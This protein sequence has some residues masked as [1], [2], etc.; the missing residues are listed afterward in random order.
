MSASQSTDLKLAEA[1]AECERLREENRRLREGMWIPEK[2]TSSLLAGVPHSPAAVTG[3]STPGE[4]VKLFRSL[5]RGR[6]DVYALRWEGRNGQAG[7]SPAYRKVWSNPLSKHPDEPKEYFP[8]TDQVIHDHLKGI[9][10]AG[11]YPLLSDETCWFLAADFDKATWQEDV[12]A[13]LRTCVEWQV[14]AILERSRSGRGGHIW[15]FFDTALPARFARK[16]G[17]AILT[18]TMEQRHQL[19]LDS[20]DR[21]FPSQDTMPKGGFGNLI[22][23]PLQQIP[24]GQGNSV[25]LAADF[26]P[27][28]DQWA[29]L[30]SIRPMTFVEVENI[31]REAERSGDIIGVRRSIADDEQ[32]EDPW[33]LPPS[34]KKKDEA[35]P[36]PLPA[37][38]RV[39]RS[40]L[41]FVEA[42]GLPSAMLNRLHRLAAF[43]NPEFYRAQAMRLSTFGKPRVIRCAEEFPKHVALPRGC[44][45]E[46]TT[47]LESHKVAVELDDQRFAG[48]SIE[49]T[50]HGQLRLDQQSAAN[51]ML[52]YD[53]GILSATTAF[54]KTVVAAW[55]IAARK[56]NTLVLVHRRQ[57]LDQWRE[58]LS[59]F[60]DLPVKSIG[61]IGG[62]RRRPN[63]L[64]DVAV[65]Q[66]LN[67]KQV[68]DDVVANYG[69]VIVDECHH[70]SAVSFEQVLRQVKA[71]YV[72]GLTATPQRKDGHHPII[73]MQC[74]PIRHRV[75]AKEQALARPFKHV[76]IP[77]PTNFRLPPSTEKPEMHELYAALANDKARNN[78][79]CVDLLRA[80][81]TKRS[82]ILLT[83]R[84]SQVDEFASRLTG[85]VK[86]IVVLKGGMGAKQR[87]AIAEQLTAIPEG[88][89]RVLLATGRY[90]GEGFD[91]ARLDTLFLAMPVS[92]R[93]TLQ[94]YVGRLH[95]L[96]DSKREVIVYDY[97]DGC[98][99]VFSAMY[100][101]RVR[102][103][104]AVGYV[105]QDE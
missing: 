80:I 46:I 2:R 16:L 96:H 6:E 79:I 36:G 85:L 26:N 76:V 102:G 37:K 21:F 55:L 11:I 38:V 54:G 82:P 73:I 29:L 5:F 95:R 62:G 10:T 90:I 43:Q 45:G 42:A 65:V 8:L 3:K 64:V 9:L 34:R 23:L 25:F 24:R 17:A 41:I 88:E 40:N 12:R 48:Q 28:P 50:F 4:K 72:T 33:T 63:G 69:H 31:V 7:Y 100:S 22:A 19:G 67:R 98:L 83:E 15:V 30:S 52:A 68:V 35:I 77:R 39:V 84:T 87:R 86:H 74:G 104:E 58:R 78:L 20:Y 81:K 66:S 71:R 14:P 94:Q 57:L 32:T 105:I 13:F 75:N 70:I 93:G 47:L 91:D 97:V 51:A 56:V 101:K 103:Y 49:V 18:R 99:P 92:W 44:L 53:D 1:L 89:E 59:T 27:H 61:Q 60:L